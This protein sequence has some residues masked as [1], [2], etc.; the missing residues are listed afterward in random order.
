M[1]FAQGKLEGYDYKSTYHVA[2]SGEEL[3]YSIDTG[4]LTVTVGTT[5]HVYRLA[6]IQGRIEVQL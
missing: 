5:R 4:V 1:T 2:G 3:T 6:D